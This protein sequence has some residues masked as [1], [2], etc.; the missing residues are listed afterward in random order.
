M[1]SG[2]FSLAIELAP[3]QENSYLALA[4]LYEKAKRFR[5]AVEI[6][7]Q[8]RKQIPGSAAF[9]LPLGNNLVW[10]EQYE[11]GATVLND[12]IRQSPKTPEAYLR[13]AEAYRNTGRTELETQTL[14][15]L[16]R[17]VPGYPMVGVLI[18]RALL[19]ASPVDYAKV[20]RTLA[21]AEEIT[22]NDSEVFFLKGKA[23]AATGRRQEA[24]AAFQHAIELRPMDPAAYYQLGLLYRQLGQA[25]LAAQIFRRMQHIEAGP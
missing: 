23:L 18:A 10:A 25:G 12:L 5:E 3:A 17:V 9:L 22:A 24:I 6:L 2:I 4:F 7:Q 16:S 19:T 8:G 13:L 14:E 21:Q 1:R 20:L 11:A 15:K